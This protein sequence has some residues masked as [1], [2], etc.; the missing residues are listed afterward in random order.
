[1]VDRLPD[2]LWMLDEADAVLA[3]ARDPKEVARLER[4]RAS[5]VHALEL[6]DARFQIE[7]ERLWKIAREGNKTAP[8]GLPAGRR[9]ALDMLFY[10]VMDGRDIPGWV[11]GEFF[12]IGNMAHHGHYKS[13]DD[14][15]GPPL[16][17]NTKH[18]SL[19]GRSGRRME[20]W[21]AVNRRHE[22]GE[23]IDQNTFDAVGEELGISGGLANKLY[24]E[25]EE[26][27]TRE[28]AREAEEK[29]F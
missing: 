3:A 9:A 18:A 14:V 27:R 11:R 12:N 4:D 15:F 28:A 22:A 7:N 25:L 20:V 24:Y 13:W 19:R 29:N 26:F 2:I 1:M 8:L 10:C 23:P 17:K 21:C 5:L 16:P 6:S